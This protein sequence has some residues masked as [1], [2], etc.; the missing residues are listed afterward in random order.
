MDVLDSTDYLE[1]VLRHLVREKDFFT[2]AKELRIQPDDFLSSQL[3]GIRLYREFARIILEFPSA[4]I[5]LHMLGM[6]VR[7]SIQNGELKSY[8][9]EYSA[10]MM[11]FIYSGELH[12][13]YML[14]TIRD[15]LRRRRQLKAQI[16]HADNLDELTK[17]LN[18]IAVELDV[19]TGNGVSHVINP[20]DQIIR[21]PITTRI[22]S[23][24]REL[25][26]VH[27]GW[28]YGEYYLMLGYPGGGKSLSGIH[29]V[30]SAALQGFKSVYFTLEE[31][32]YDVV[33]R[34]YADIFDIDYSALHKGQA[35]FELEEA[36]RKLD[37]VKKALLS[38]IRFIDLRDKAPCSVKILQF[39][40]E[41]LADSGFLVD[42]VVT[43][44]MDYLTSYQD[45]SLTGWE[46]YNKVN[47]EYDLFTHTKIG[48]EKPFVGILNH[49][50]NGKLKEFFT[51]ED[52][53]GLK[54]MDKPT[55]GCFGYGRANQMSDEI[56][57]FSLK[58]RH[59]K[60]FA[61]KYKVDFAHMRY[62][63]KISFQEM[64]QVEELVTP[65]QNPM[66]QSFDNCIIKTV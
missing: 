5:D 63:E 37:P 34:L 14:S 31:P 55:D 43:D 62:V 32:Y 50:V 19:S 65:T 53:N 52:I 9:L 57:L 40:L 28:G 64:N 16:E 18:Q 49:Q 13:D 51:R 39:E 42:V 56:N 20:V 4:P 47:F 29:Y 22:S 54:S 27:G 3:A 15:W 66:T 41:K 35:N 21:K 23:G 38:N 46:L 11:S 17:K 61:I 7:Q 58:S 24:L 30:K 48:G 59:S 33:Q 2:Y 36:M 6:H 12:K 25:D 1:N 8:P 44:Q 26:K 60:N 10:K 45:S